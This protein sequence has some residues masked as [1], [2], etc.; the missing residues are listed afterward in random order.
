MTYQEQIAALHAGYNNTLYT[1]SMTRNYRRSFITGAPKHN[2]SSF[3]CSV[4]LIVVVDCRCNLRALSD[5]REAEGLGCHTCDADFGRVEGLPG[6]YLGNQLH[7]SF[8]TDARLQFEKYVQ[9]K[10]G[11]SPLRTGGGQGVSVRDFRDTSIGAPQVTFNG[12]ARW[13]DLNQPESY[14][15]PE[16][17]RCASTRDPRKCQ[18]HLHGPSSWHDGQGAFC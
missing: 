12:G 16:C 17:N 7:E 8:R 4:L 9:T 3:A 15:Y 13:Q 10:V 1:L 2:E 18:L 14:R 5:V 6:V 11:C